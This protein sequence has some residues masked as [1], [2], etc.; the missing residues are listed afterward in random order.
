[1]R[2][3]FYS[4]MAVIIASVG[5]TACSSDGGGNF[6]KPKKYDLPEEATTIV[7]EEV[8]DQM[9]AQDFPINEG[10][11]PPILNGTFVAD[12]WKLIYTSHNKGWKVDTVLNYSVDRK[13]VV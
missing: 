7:P 9:K 1:M 6:K 4:I 5:F 8:L 10:T 3:V 11:N 13:S 12:T 2:K